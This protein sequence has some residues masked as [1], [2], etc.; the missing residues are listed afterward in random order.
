MNKIL[1]KYKLK[2][3]YE[4][5]LIGSKKEQ[6]QYVGFLFRY[7]YAKRLSYKI[8]KNP[9][10]NYNTHKIFLQSSKINE[11]KIKQGCFVVSFD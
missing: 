8:I 4:K 6:T 10:K 7:Y 1:Y 11:L 2:N 5:T 9:N 3:K